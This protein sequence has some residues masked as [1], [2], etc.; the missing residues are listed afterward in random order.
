[1]STKFLTLFPF[2]TDSKI[3]AMSEDNTRCV[4]RL[5]DVPAGM[6]RSDYWGLG[7]NPKEDNNQRLLEWFNAHLTENNLNWGKGR[8]DGD[9][10]DTHPY[11]VAMNADE[12]RV[13]QPSWF[14]DLIGI[15]TRMQRDEVIPEKDK[16]TPAEL[17][18]AKEMWSAA[19]SASYTKQAP[20][21]AKQ[22]RLDAEKKAKNVPGVSTHGSHVLD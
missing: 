1:M 2:S 9:N 19:A 15:Y 8:V 11:Y 12:L 5:C 3:V 7:L 21:L 18:R 10:S 22:A 13:A 20:E 4:I 16:L 17:V 6:H 14:R